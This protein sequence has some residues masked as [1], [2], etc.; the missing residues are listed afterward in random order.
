MTYDFCQA[1]KKGKQ[2][3]KTCNFTLNLS[4]YCRKSQIESNL[5]HHCIKSN[6]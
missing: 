2:W 5:K 6:L 3:Q 4:K 1:S